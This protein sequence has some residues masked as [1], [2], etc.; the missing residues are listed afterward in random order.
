MIADTKKD[1]TVIID[2]ISDNPNV[3]YRIP[4]GQIMACSG[5]SL[6]FDSVH[7]IL[8]TDGQTLMDLMQ[9]DNI[10]I[11]LGDFVYDNE[12]KKFILKEKDN[13]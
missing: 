3:L 7:I 11:D 4:T 12:L 5:E 13:A 6:T 10:T 9:M 1:E 2:I 8:N